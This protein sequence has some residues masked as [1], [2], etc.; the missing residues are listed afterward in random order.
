MNFNQQLQE[1]Y[2]AGYYRA[3]YEGEEG[4]LL[5]TGT[6]IDSPINPVAYGK[7]PQPINFELNDVKPGDEGTSLITSEVG[8]RMW[9]I[10]AEDKWGNLVPW[11][12]HKGGPGS[13]APYRWRRDPPRGWVLT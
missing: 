5:Q 11:Y 8:A 6:S 12:Y 9:T 7:V 2:E 13:M 4:Q 10:L 1:A 3:L